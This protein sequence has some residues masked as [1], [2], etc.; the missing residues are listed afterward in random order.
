MYQNSSYAAERLNNSLVNSLCGRVFF[1]RE[2]QCNRVLNVFDI[3][4][5]EEV[6]INLDDVDPIPVQLGFCNW[7]KSAYFLSRKPIRKWKQGLTTENL[8]V[9]GKNSGSGPDIM[10]SA[11]ADVVQNIYPSVPKAMASLK[12]GSLLKVGVARN[13]A[14]DNSGAVFYRLKAVGRWN[15]DSGVEID[16][17]FDYLTEEW[18]EAV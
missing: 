14:L 9:D 10:Q 7:K 2:V 8:S 12:K 16:T 6:V 3:R 1:V 13:W 17:R 11:I 5:R 4:S 15:E 18:K